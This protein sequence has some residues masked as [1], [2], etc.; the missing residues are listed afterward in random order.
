[1][2]KIVCLSPSNQ[3]GNRYAYGNTVESE[4]CQR[5]ADCCKTAL[6]RCGIKVIM[7][8]NT[9]GMAKKCQLSDQGNADLH[10]PIHTN[11]GG[12]GFGGT[13]VFC[14]KASESTQGYLAASA[15]LKRLAPIT[16][17][18][19]SER[20][21]ENS[22]LF[23]ISTPKAPTAYIEVEFHDVANYAKWI[24]DNV[25]LIGETITQGICDY[26]NVPYIPEGKPTPVDPGK[27]KE[28]SK[29]ARAKAISKGIINGVGKNPDGSINYAWDQPVTREQLVTIFDR[30]NL[31]N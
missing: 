22:T 11:A 15:I 14:S 25:K 2:S 26:F 31:L 17:G 28:Y 8:D 18:N 4:Q 9:L 30:L 1:M 20:V 7:A 5:I 13:R 12:K 29:E 27:G 21:S 24:I 3:D 23:E 6:E 10:V 19:T 16:P